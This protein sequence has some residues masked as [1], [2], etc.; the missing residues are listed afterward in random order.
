M[1]IKPFLFLITLFF[2]NFGFAQKLHLCFKSTDSA[3]IED[4]I[5]LSF[6]VIDN[7]WANGFV[8][9]KG[10]KGGLLLTFSEEKIL[11]KGE[12]VNPTLVQYSFNEYTN[13]KISGKYFLAIAGSNV[14]GFYYYDK[15]R[16]SKIN[17]AQD[18][19]TGEKCGCDW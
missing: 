8:H 18:F 6:N 5:Q 19:S 12:G 14:T 1:Q 13:G 3:Y 10:Q 17:F 7:D 11:E 9:Y 15:R 16:K 4:P 2:I